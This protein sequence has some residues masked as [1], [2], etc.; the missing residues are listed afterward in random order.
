MSL[1]CFRGLASPDRNM[2]RPILIIFGGTSAVGRNLAELAVQEGI[3]VVLTYFRR[4]KLASELASKLSKTRGA[5]AV[6]RHCDARDQAA[7]ADVFASL[8]RSKLTRPIYVANCVGGNIRCD[9]SR[10]T[11]AILDETMRLNVAPAMWILAQLEALSRAG[12]RGACIVLTSTAG[13][14]PAAVSPHY[15]AAKAA[16]NQLVNVFARTCAPRFRVNAVAPGVIRSPTRRHRVVATRAIPLRRY[17]NAREI[18]ALV[19]WMLWHETY[20]T[21]QIIVSDGGMLL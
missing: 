2:A 13:V 17:A 15:C 10:I 19:A 6:E 9:T 16:V 18:A 20:V 3:D 14:R 11:G 12:A 8:G 7:V 4:R 21:G 1:D 5:S